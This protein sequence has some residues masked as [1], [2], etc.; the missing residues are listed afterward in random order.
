MG[1]FLFARSCMPSDADDLVAGKNYEALN[2]I[3]DDGWTADKMWWA[4]LDLVF[5]PGGAT[6]L[7]ASSTTG[8]GD[9]LVM[10]LDRS[11]VADMARELRGLDL[12]TIQTRFDASAFGDPNGPSVMP[13]DRE[14]L[15]AAAYALREMFIDAATS[16][17]EVLW[18][19]D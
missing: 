4:A 17:H 2:W 13:D 12:A 9:E 6:R 5:G 3:V 16:A 10:R 11:R 19:Y 1:M 14:W 15:C 7:E 8:T 18:V